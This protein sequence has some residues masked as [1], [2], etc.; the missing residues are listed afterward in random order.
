VQFPLC[1]D[2][3][4]PALEERTGTSTYKANSKKGL[5]ELRFAES[6]DTARDVVG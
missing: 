5:E 2:L 4:L 6:G 3:C 1:L